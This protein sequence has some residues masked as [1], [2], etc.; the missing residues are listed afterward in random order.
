MSRRKQRSATYGELILQCPH[1]HELCSY[2]LTRQG[3]LYR[4]DRRTQ[5]GEKIKAQCPACREE[6]RFPDYQASW[7]V[8]AEQ[9]QQQLRDTRSERRFLKLS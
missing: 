6:G 5:P 7:A 1:G 9:L 4:D 2:L 8:V 3:D